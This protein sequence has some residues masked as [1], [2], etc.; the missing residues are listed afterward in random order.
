MITTIITRKFVN[1]P[2]LSLD[3]QKQREEKVIEYYHAHEKEF[4][5]R[6][7]L[8]RLELENIVQTQKELSDELIKIGIEDFTDI[9]LE[10]SFIETYAITSAV[11]AK[12]AYEYIQSHPEWIEKLNEKTLE[13]EEQRHQFFSNALKVIPAPLQKPTWEEYRCNILTV[14][15]GEFYEQFWP[16]L[17]K[18]IGNS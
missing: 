6:K 16:Y 9:D 18:K 2:L 12:F 10:D 15:D 5:G 7:M 13:Y 17:D 1:K 14:E 11:Y 3:E 8:Y 4:E